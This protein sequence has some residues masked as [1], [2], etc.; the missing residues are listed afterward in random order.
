M[1]GYFG[2]FYDTWSA[3]F[4]VS[5]DGPNKKIIINPGIESINV[6][7]D[8]YS[9]W[10]RWQLFAETENMMFLS[11][12]RTFGGDP[13]VEGQVAPQYFFLTNGWRVV[14]IAQHVSF[15]S[16]LYTDEGDSPFI[17]LEG[18]TISNA[19]A[20]VPTVGGA[21]PEEIWGYVNR[22]LTAVVDANIVSVTDTPVTDIDDFKGLTQ[23]QHDKLMALVNYDDKALK[24]LAYAILAQ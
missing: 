23:E 10:K 11:A 14:V 16:N 13:T 19:T 4:L 21:T 5:F 20:D 3:D 12:F 22:Q 18:G 15:A 7:V 9:A 17:Q 6:Q 8:L 1:L 24:N 2:G